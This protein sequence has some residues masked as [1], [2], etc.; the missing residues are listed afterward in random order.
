MVLLLL[1]MVTLL[2]LM[3]IFISYPFPAL[4]PIGLSR[5]DNGC[6]RSLQQRLDIRSRTAGFALPLARLCQL[7]TCFRVHK[8]KGVQ[9]GFFWTPTPTFPAL[10]RYW[11]W[12]GFRSVCDIR[13]SCVHTGECSVCQPLHSRRRQRG[14]PTSALRFNP[15]QVPNAP[16]SVKPWTCLILAASFLS[17]R[18]KIHIFSLV[19]L[20]IFGY[21]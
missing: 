6:S 7:Y 19:K 3:V 4:W 11:F 14:E 18:L 15:V 1:L 16:S 13:L 17:A 20:W 10:Y 8:A 21:N 12:C 2:L 5:Q 9:Y